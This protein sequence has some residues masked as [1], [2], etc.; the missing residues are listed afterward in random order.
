MA[1]N[2]QYLQDLSD[3]FVQDLRGS[4]YYRNLSQPEKNELERRLHEE[5]LQGRHPLLP[6]ADEDDL[7]RLR[8]IAEQELGVTLPVSIQEVLRQ[9]DGF[10]ENGVTL[11]GVD[12]EIRGVEFESGPGLIAENSVTWS[13]TPETARRYLFIG[14]SDLWYFAI[15]IETGL[16]VV[17]DRLSLTREHPFSSVEEMVEDMLEQALGIFGEHQQDE[18]EVQH[19]KD[20]ENV[21]FR[22]SNN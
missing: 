13:G 17:L 12:A 19:Q 20:L 2:E 7:A 1:L 22:F 15:E 14:D 6:G 21:R 16:P 11:Y 8:E 10:V 5:S 4:D 9:V 18:P 3:L